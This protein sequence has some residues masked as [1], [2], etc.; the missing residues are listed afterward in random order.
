MYIFMQNLKQH[1]QMNAPFFKGSKIK[2][3]RKK[4]KLGK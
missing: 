3:F 4:E 1:K 2:I